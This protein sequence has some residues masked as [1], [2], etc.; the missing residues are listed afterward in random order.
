[1]DS[2]QPACGL[3]LGHLPELVLFWVGKDGAILRLFLYALSFS[4]GE[5]AYGAGLLHLRINGIL[6]IYIKLLSVM[7]IL[8]CQLDIQD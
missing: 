1:L 8:V 3:L 2:F 4:Q 7:A 6:R 5:L